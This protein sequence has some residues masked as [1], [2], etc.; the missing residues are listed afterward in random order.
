MLV[1]STPGGPGIAQSSRHRIGVR[2]TEECRDLFQVLFHNEM[3]FVNFPYQP[4]EP[5]LI[6]RVELPPGNSH[7]FN[8]TDTADATTQKVKYSHPID[9]YSHFSQTG[10]V[11]TTVY[12]QACRLDM[13]VGHFFS[14]DFS[15][16]TLF[17]KCRS[18][19]P[20]VQFSFDTADPV[21]P[22]HCAGY[23]LQLSSAINLGAIGN[24]IYWDA[25]G[26]TIQA[27]AIAPPADSLFNGWIL[28]ISA[29]R[30]LDD[31]AVEPG[32]FGL[33][34][35]GGFAENLYDAMEPSSFLA[36]QYPADTDISVLRL[37]D[38]VRSAD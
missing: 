5:G 25:D 8:L 19:V 20:S 23:W 12:N 31:L 29:R 22:L 37:I 10:K 27:L 9:G 24:P 6:A 2:W 34:F 7:T 30:G 35:V 17:R 18:R 16:V 13:S 3:I 36:M 32:K 4:D 26:R 21:D 11:R 15:G 33:R 28:G 14:V 38:Y 1:T